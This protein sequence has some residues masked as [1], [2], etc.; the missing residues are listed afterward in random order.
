MVSPYTG[1]WIEISRNNLEHAVRI[2]SPYTGEWIEI[3]THPD[4]YYKSKSHLTQVSGLKS[5]YRS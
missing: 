3:S 5:I 1:E 4:T 2:V